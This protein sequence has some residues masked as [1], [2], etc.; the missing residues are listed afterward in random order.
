M[1]PWRSWNDH[2]FPPWSTARNQSVPLSWLSSGSP[3][4]GMWVH[5]MVA[6]RT[7]LVWHVWSSTFWSLFNHHKHRIPLVSFMMTSFWPMTRII[8]VSSPVTFSITCCTVS[9][10][11]NYIDFGSESLYCFFEMMFRSV[12]INFFSVSW[13]TW[14]SLADVKICQFWSSMLLV[15]NTLSARNISAYANSKS[16]IDLDMTN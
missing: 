7:T 16:W 3:I 5:R 9:P 11:E 6:I 13:V 12:L 14:L 4:E 2:W 15:N 1:L 8:W 10:D